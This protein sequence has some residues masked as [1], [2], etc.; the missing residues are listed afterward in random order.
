MAISN[1]TGLETGD[2]IELNTLNGTAS[3]Q[4]TTKRTGTYALQCNPT[5]TA[6]GSGELRAH[7]IT[8]TKSLFNAP[9]LHITFHFRV[10]TLPAANNEIICAISG[11]VVE[12]RVSSG[13]VLSLYTGTT[14]NA[15][16][17]AVLA[18]DT[19]YQI[20]IRVD[21]TG[22]TQE[23]RVDRVVDI[24]GSIATGA[25]SSAVFFG[26]ST[27][28]NGNTVNF[29]YDDMAFGGSGGY[30]DE[31][32]VKLGIAI[33]AGA[34]AGWT[35]GTGTTFA[36][37]DD[38]PHDGD[39]TYIQASAVQD[40][41]DHT[42]DMQAAATIGLQSTIRA[43]KPMV[44]PRT[45]STAGA[46]TVAHRLLSGGSGFELS[47]LELTTSFQLLARVDETDPF[48][49][50]AWTATKFD[51]VEVGMAANAIAQ[52]QRFTAVYVSVW[53]VAVTQVQAPRSM[54]QYR[55]R[56]V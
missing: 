24:T 49:S 47:A 46:S 20:D 34:A 28:R 8:G 25:A 54:H 19:W 38:L 33:G 50:A 52:V 35:N 7:S 16:G 51:T 42:F 41:L 15:T 5:T 45:T 1:F 55:Q 21:D 36:E 6:I 9:V 40:N 26:K 14:L 12:V 4:S 11:S 13:G 43:V 10:G 44:I 22:N 2:A 27:N 37:V 53:S 3:I 29:Y 17:T 32:E 23:V 56:R 39:T 48:D 30:P 31:G 18:L